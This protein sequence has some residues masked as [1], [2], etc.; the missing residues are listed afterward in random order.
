M[1]LSA[2]GAVCGQIYSF[3]KQNCHVQENVGIVEY[4]FGFKSNLTLNHIFLE[5]KKEIFYNFD[6]NIG[7]GAFCEQ[8][9][10]K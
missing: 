10:H 7:V 2:R 9:I 4:I 1:V 3:L 5:F 8:I 6:E